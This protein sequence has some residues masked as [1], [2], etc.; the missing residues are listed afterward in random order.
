ME[1]TTIIPAD[2]F[3]KIEFSYTYSDSR[4]FDPY[5]VIGFIIDIAGL[6]GINYENQIIL[7]Y[8][9]TT[10]FESDDNADSVIY[11]D[12]LTP[13][14][15]SFDFAVIYDDNTNS[16]NLLSLTVDTIVNLL[17]KQETFA[18]F[19]LSRNLFTISNIVKLSFL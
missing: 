12:N 15:Y 3:L 9:N 4:N 10:I 16:E 2:N 1:A 5:T 19:F 18:A 11:F 14:E 7:T 8:D 17:C 13:G 6:N